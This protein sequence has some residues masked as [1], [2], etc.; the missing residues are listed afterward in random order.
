MSG[1]AWVVLA[2]V[3]VLVIL[4]V[5]YAK[6]QA[7]ATGIR[8][9]LERRELTPA[10]IQSEQDCLAA[11]GSGYNYCPESGIH[12]CDGVCPYTAACASKDNIL[13]GACAKPVPVPPSQIKSKQDCLDSGGSGYSYCPGSGVHYCNGACNGH[14]GCF[15]GKLG[16]GACNPPNIAPADIRT[17]ADCLAM[18]GT[19]GYCQASG[20][21]YCH[22]VCHKNVPC[23]SDGK[24]S[25]GACQDAPPPLKLN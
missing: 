22:G 17:E 20:V 5:A 11:G 4:A 14:A 15:G 24:L 12:Y 6:K 1:G 21:A 7:H 13:I 25:S 3:V 9:V 10:D 2:V 19:Y 16:A 23:S 8:G 18:N